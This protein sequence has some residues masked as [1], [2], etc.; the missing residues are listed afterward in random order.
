MLT[1][2]SGPGLT[3]K[4]Q[5]RHEEE[6]YFTHQVSSCAVEFTPTNLQLCHANGSRSV[7][8]SLTS[9]HIH[10]SGRRTRHKDIKLDERSGCIIWYLLEVNVDPVLS[11]FTDCTK[12]GASPRRKSQRQYCSEGL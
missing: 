5:S 2:N 4:F 10:I 8:Y 7:I 6:H 3:R 1:E 9:G 12:Q 11:G